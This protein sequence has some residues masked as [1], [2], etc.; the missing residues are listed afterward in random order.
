MMLT[1]ARTP[2]AMPS[3]CLTGNSGVVRLQATI[4][5]QVTDAAAYVLACEHIKPAL[6][7]LFAASAVAV[8]AAREL[9]AI[10]D[11]AWHLSRPTSS[12]IPGHATGALQ[13][14]DLLAAINR[15]LAALTARAQDSA[16]RSSRIDLTA[17]SAGGG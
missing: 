2:D 17:S 6:R 4:F 16:S 1:S 3:F 10:I 11:G 8:C 13:D 12:R 5:Y 14:A 9:D 7:R 15:R